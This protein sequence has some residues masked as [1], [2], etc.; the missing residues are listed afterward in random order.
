MHISVRRLI[1]IFFVLIF[2]VAAP[3]VVFYTAGYRL[4]ISNRHLQQ[5]GVLAITTY[6]RGGSIILNGQGLAQKTPYVIQ[7]IMPNLHEVVLQKK[8]YHEWSQKIRVDEGKTSY[9]TARLFAD[10]EPSVLDGSAITLALRTHDNQIAP[11]VDNAS[12]RFFDNGANIEV[13]TGTGAGEELIAL[14]PK[15]TYRLLEEDVDYILIADE[16]NLGFIIARQGG[17]VVELPTAI[18]AFDWLVNENLLIWTD[19]NEVNTY[20]AVSGEKTFITREGQTVT[21]VAWHPEADSFFVVSG[22]TL[23]AYDRNVHET[24]EVVPLLVDTNMQDIWLDAAG[25]NLF[26]AETQITSASTTPPTIYNLPL[27]Q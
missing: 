8:G 11:I 21:D 15:G 20:D 6:P 26:F 19:G 22:T 3:L 16:R 25:K 12:I 9:I 7:R 23:L 27:V 4:N 14:L 18:A 24:R 10:T 1:F 13:R 17:E 2:V 5:T